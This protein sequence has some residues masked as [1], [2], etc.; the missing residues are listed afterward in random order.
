MFFFGV[1]YYPE[2]WP[3][4]RWP[5]DAAMMKAAGFNVARLA[6][7]AWARI[8]S[9]EGVFEFTWLDRAIQTLFDQGIRVVLGTPTASPPAWLMGA[10]SGLFRVRD[11]GLPIAYGNRREYC[12]NHPV[13]H[14]HTRRIVEQMADHYAGHPAVIGWQIDNEFGERCYC[15]VCRE[16]FQAW[17]A[18]RYGSLDALNRAWGTVFW[19]HTF[20]NL[21]QIPLPLKTGGAHNPG[22]A[23]DFCRFVSDSYAAYQRMQIQI[24]RERCPGRFVTHNMMGFD[25]D[26]IDYFRLADDLDFVSLTQYPRNQWKFTPSPDYHRTALQYDTTRG[27]KGRSFWV[28]E[29]QVGQ[30]GWEILSVLPRPGEARLWAYQAIAGG[31]DGIVFF[32]WRT[33]RYGTEQNW[34]GLLDADARPTRRYA[35]IRR[36]GAEISCLGEELQGSTVR[37]R[38]AMILS[39]DSRFA[40]QI[41]PQ[42]PAFSYAAHFQEVY[43]AFRRRGVTLDILHPEAD[44]SDY[45]LVI[46]PSLFVLPDRAAEN[47][48]RY[49]Q[50]G[51]TLLLTQ[52]SGV[53]DEANALVELP[54]PGLL[55]ELCGIEVEEVD[56]LA[57]GMK[58][59]IEFCLPGLERARTEIGVL[60]E[61]LR[62]NGAE[63]VAQYCQDYY[64]GRPAITRNR[65]GE[66]Q[67]VYVGAVGAAEL[68]NRLAG[69][70]VDLVG[71]QPLLEASDGVEATERW[72]DGRR[73]LFLLNHHGQAERVRLGRKMVDLLDH[74]DPREEISLEPYGVAVLAE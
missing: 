15:P 34:Q 72:K 67:A 49:V 54:A 53:K 39:S 63:L 70:L 47:L 66:G 68:Y 35:E 22:L 74:D 45:A 21:S 44:L 3:E 37:A 24:L 18:V 56:S 48:R 33:A 26:Q 40:F 30:S 42:N 60:C 16:R 13:Y 46:A 69:W 2:Q 23:L 19:G 32:R 38:A 36:M 50:A 17:L 14:A 1:D 64:A 27:L 25:F 62:L 51:G 57:E 28:M 71:I 31:A 65:F 4:E 58:N 41:Q 43:K 8:E 10:N 61:V 5:A 9:Q 59:E 6:E 52:R 55:A 73:L 29:Q 11:D 7:F 20:T 12:P